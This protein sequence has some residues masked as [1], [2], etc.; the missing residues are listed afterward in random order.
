MRALV[1]GSRDW[2]DQKIVNLVLT[3][4][5]FTYESLEIVEGCAPGADRCGEVFGR[6]F[7]AEVH[8]FPADWG[9]HGKGAG[10][11][12]NQQMLD[13]GKPKVAIG[14][15]DNFNGKKGYGGTE[16]MARRAKEAGIPT[17]IISHGDGV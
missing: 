15:K 9:K 11:I 1:F 6:D 10:H 17:Y 16:D 12:R 7:G 2:E 3:G 8:H 4:L 5:Q 13:E 14:F